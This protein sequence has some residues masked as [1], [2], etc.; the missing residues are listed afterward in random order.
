MAVYTTDI[1][2]NRPCSNFRPTNSGDDLGIYFSD[3]S[4]ISLDHQESNSRV[5]SKTSFEVF[6]NV[7]GNFSKSKLPRKNTSYD[8]LDYNRYNFQTVITRTRRCK[9]KELIKTIAMI[10]FAL[11]CFVIFIV[12]IILSVINTNTLP[13]TDA[14]TQL[15]PSKGTT[16]AS[17]NY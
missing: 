1:D 4:N 16:K 15:P 11:L 7:M 6:R 14:P 2:T 17:G 10:L 5:S 12:G 13:T 8:E 9:S 3:V